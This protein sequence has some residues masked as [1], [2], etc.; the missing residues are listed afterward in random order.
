MMIDEE[1]F[2]QLLLAIFYDVYNRR[3]TS[4][5]WTNVGYDTPFYDAGGDAPGQV[6]FQGDQCYQ[7][8][9]VNYVAQG[10]LAHSQTLT[11]FGGKLLYVYPWKAG[12]YFVR[13]AF[14]S[15]PGGYSSPKPSEGTIH[16]YEFG[17]QLY[18]VLFYSVDPVGIRAHQGG[19]P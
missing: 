7:R 19:I 12:N 15:I 6:C 11:E 18:S 2:D 3:Y 1:Q 8:S 5:P 4:G 13:R 16:W 9:E 17:H 10:M 14:P